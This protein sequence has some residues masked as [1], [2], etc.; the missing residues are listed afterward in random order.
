MRDL[1]YNIH[2]LN[3]IVLDAEYQFD[4]QKLTVYYDAPGKTEFK[5]FITALYS[6][7][8]VRIMLEQR[9]KK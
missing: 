5:K 3:L 2:N 8:K 6:T 1:A 7:F 4:R 9:E